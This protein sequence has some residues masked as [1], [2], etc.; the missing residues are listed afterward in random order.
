M[1]TRRKPL[2]KTAIVVPPNEEVDVLQ[3]STSATVLSSKIDDRQQHALISRGQSSEDYFDVYD[4]YH[5]DL[6]KDEDEPPTYQEHLSLSPV[7]HEEAFHQFPEISEIQTAYSTIP[8]HDDA[9]DVVGEALQT[10]SITPTAS[11]PS[12]LEP[13]PNDVTAGKRPKLVTALEETSLFLGG[14]LSHPVETNKHFTILRHSHG[15]VYYKGPETSLAI[16]IFS[17]QP[18]PTSRRLWLQLKGWSGNTGMAAKALFRSN[19]SW[20]NVTP[21]NQIPAEELPNLDE[22]AWQRDI[23]KFMAKA[24]KVQ[25][26]HILRETAVIRIPFEASDGYFRLVLTNEESKRVLCPSPVFRVASTSMSAS[27]LKGASLKTLPIEL[28]VKAAQV[29]AQVASAK[30]IAA[31]KPLIAANSL[32]SSMAPLQ[33]Y[34]SY[35]QT[36]WNVSGM[37]EHVVNA[38]QQFNARQERQ[39]VLDRTLSA[40]MAVRGGII[41]DEAGP[42]SPF[43]V[44]LNGVIAKGTGNSTTAFDMPTANLDNLPPDLLS[45]ISTGVYFGWALVVPHDP[46]QTHLH[47]AWRQA[48]IT[49]SFLAVSTSKIAQRKT[50]RIYL[51]HEYPPNTLFIGSKLKVSIMGYLRPLTDIDDEDTFIFETLNDIATARASLDRPAWDHEQMLR[52]V[53]TAQAERGISDRLVDV[54]VAGQRKFDKIPIHKLGVRSNSFGIHDRGMYGNGGVW[55]KRD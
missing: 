32:V 20:I 48:I 11:A 12:T 30:A 29:A 10:T 54:R 8:E 39:L 35:A 26:R 5:D 4:E 44:R 2:P 47:D 31:A 25:Q 37:E 27:S 7:Q 40:P 19:N 13:A 43:P 53:R 42:A 50:V 34:G 46:K 52:R 17:S 14:L 23:R 55:V 45:S 6:D 1:T 33:Q 51:L 3:P 41:G 15:L 28:S 16:S 18:L 21:E 22:R 49:V 38:N 9:E 36:A 24:T